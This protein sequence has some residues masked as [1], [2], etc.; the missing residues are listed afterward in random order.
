MDEITKAVAPK[1]DHQIRLLEDRR[2]HE[3][4]L[5]LAEKLGK[6]KYTGKACHERADGIKDGTALPPIEL[7]ENQDE[8][9]QMRDECIAAAKKARQDA[10]DAQRGKEQRAQA[11]AAAKK[12]ETEESNQ[13]KIQNALQKRAE[14][15]EAERIREERNENK[16]KMKQ[17]RLA[18]LAQFRAEKAWV[19]TRK[20][21][22]RALYRQL[23]GYNIDGKTP[24]R[25]R[26]N[27]DGY[28]S[29]EAEVTDEFESDEEEIIDLADD[30]ETDEDGN[31]ESD[32]ENAAEEEIAPCTKKACVPKNLAGFVRAEVTKDTLLNPRSIMSDAELVRLLFYRDLPRRSSDESHAEV[33]ARLAASDEAL[34]SEELSQLLIHLNEKSKG[35]KP[36][37]IARL[38]EA[39][40]KACDAGEMG[41]K[42]TDLSFMQRYE[43]YTGEF[44]YLVTKAE[45]K[46]E[47]GVEVEG[48]D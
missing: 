42:S 14:K 11:R 3:I 19:K 37:K 18:V 28:E 16:K 33:V 12:R 2:W 27:K 44:A 17:H 22:E 4:S 1:F 36:E 45:Q 24:G 46:A 43:G 8:R 7:A 30:E 47:R 23:T 6:R 32:D 21:A 25:T 9:R 34:K 13:K 15:E 38:Q 29:E 26:K 20:Q 40:A 41:V 31:A 48:D 35:K 39:D 5:H 10:K